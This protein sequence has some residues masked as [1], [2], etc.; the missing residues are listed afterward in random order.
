MPAHSDHATQDVSVSKGGKLHIWDTYTLFP[1]GTPQT[2]TARH[3][4]QWQIQGGTGG[5][6]PPLYFSYCTIL[7]IDTILPVNYSNPIITI[8]PAT[9][10]TLCVRMHID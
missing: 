1:F 4:L 10:H 7:L 3:A 6:C 2:Q 9:Y 8:Q 5:T